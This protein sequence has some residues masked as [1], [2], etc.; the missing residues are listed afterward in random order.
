M[1]IVETIGGCN[2]TPAIVTGSLTP[3]NNPIVPEL[4]V[5]QE[6]PTDPVVIS[7]KRIQ[8]LGRRRGI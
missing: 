6:D 7:P 4:V 1:S 2:S 8:D 5:E 3:V